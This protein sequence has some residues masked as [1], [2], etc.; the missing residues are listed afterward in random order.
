MGK[1][2][3]RSDTWY[4][5]QERLKEWWSREKGRAGWTP[6]T[7]EG[8]DEL[9]TQVL[10]AEGHRSWLEEGIV[11]FWR[12]L[13][14]TGASPEAESVAD[15]TSLLA[16]YGK[17]ALSHHLSPAAGN[18]DAAFEEELCISVETKERNEKTLENVKN[19]K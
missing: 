9:Q 6:N 11:F 17:K 4:L 2:Y 8:K 7:E 19:E 1:W 18:S 10:S 13:E 3:V 12:G 5:N 14:G 15:E 16:Q